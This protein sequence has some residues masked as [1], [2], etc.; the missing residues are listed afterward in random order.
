MTRSKSFIRPAIAAAIV[1]A[2]FAVAP[3]HAAQAQR[4]SLSDIDQKL[5]G[6]QDTLGPVP[7]PTEPDMQEQIDEL[8]Q[9]LCTILPPGAPGVLG[10]C[11]KVVFVTSTTSNGELG[12][13]SGADAI[14]NV[15][16]TGAG[17]PGTYKA[18]L[19]DSTASPS[20][21]F[22][23]ST[24]PYVLVDGTLVALD[25]HDL[26]DGSL[27]SAIF[28]TETGS[29]YLSLVWSATTGAGSPIPIN[30]CSGWSSRS[31]T[32]SG[33]IGTA[34]AS[35]DGRWSDVSNVFSCD[36]SLAFYCFQQ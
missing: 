32:Q 28:R 36:R 29:T 18:W 19:S 23:R 6:V 10:R 1:A 2:F 11:N 5:D 22:T 4:S 16:A 13:L 30:H 9:M 7:G 25:Y 24:V 17:L 8:R 33:A 14:C 34:A 12:G 20:T 15:R 27:D 31:D 35:S 3:Y 21:R 26:T